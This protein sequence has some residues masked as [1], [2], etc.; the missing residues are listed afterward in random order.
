MEAHLFWLM[1]GSGLATVSLFICT[2]ILKERKTQR[3]RRV[4]LRRLQ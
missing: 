3:L 1:I 2:T 4:I